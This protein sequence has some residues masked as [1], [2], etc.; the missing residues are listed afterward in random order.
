MAF[1]TMLVLLSLPL[2][3]FSLELEPG[4]DVVNTWNISQISFFRNTTIPIGEF[5]SLSTQFTLQR[6]IPVVCGFERGPAPKEP[7]K[8]C[9]WRPSPI[10]TRC[11]YARS[12]KDIVNGWHNCQE[13]SNMPEGEEEVLPDIQRRLKWRVIDIEESIGEGG[14]PRNGVSKNGK[15]FKTMTIEVVQV[16]PNTQ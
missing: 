1:N 11:N 2:F 8:P 3:V 13:M 15:S 10:A 16:F 4:F 9:S 14:G 6:T 5:S 7:R 12:S